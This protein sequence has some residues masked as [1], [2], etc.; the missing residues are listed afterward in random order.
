MAGF[1]LTSPEL[2]EKRYKT[3]AKHIPNATEIG[4]IGGEMQ[5]SVSGAKIA[6]VLAAGL[7][8]NTTSQ[9]G[10]AEANSGFLGHLQ[11]FY[12]IKR[13]KPYPENRKGVGKMI[14]KPSREYVESLSSYVDDQGETHA[15][16]GLTKCLAVNVKSLNATDEEKDIIERYLKEGVIL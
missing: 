15:L 16:K 9:V 3:R 4:G 7:M 6:G 10:N 8:T 5:K 12:V 2:E 1:R 11:P 13:K 14:G